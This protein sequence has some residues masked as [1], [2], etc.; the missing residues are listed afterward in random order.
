MIRALSI[1]ALFAVVGSPVNDRVDHALWDFQPDEAVVSR[2][3]PFPA[4]FTEGWPEDDEALALRRGIAKLKLPG[5]TA[6]PTLLW[7]DAPPPPYG[8]RHTR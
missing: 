1:A 3:E 8:R 4:A 5:L 2:H 7:R 6:P